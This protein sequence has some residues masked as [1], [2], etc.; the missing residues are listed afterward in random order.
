MVNHHLGLVGQ[1]LQQAAIQAHHLQAGHLLLARHVAE[2]V[3][4]NRGVP[5]MSAKVANTAYFVAHFAVIAS[6]VG[7]NGL[8]MKNRYI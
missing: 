6:A 4:P 7:T 8:D 2:N 1:S 3:N 5:G